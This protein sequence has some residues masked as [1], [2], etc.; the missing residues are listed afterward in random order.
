MPLAR[1]CTFL[2][3]AF[4]CK[5]QRQVWDKFS[6]RESSS[7]L[8]FWEIW[9][10]PLFIRLFKKKSTPS[11]FLIACFAGKLKE[12]NF[13]PV[14]FPI[15]FLGAFWNVAICGH[16]WNTVYYTVIDLNWRYCLRTKTEL[17][18]KALIHAL[19]TF[20]RGPLGLVSMQNRFQVRAPSTIMKVV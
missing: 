14:F 16:L 2:S 19:F 20:S 5:T 3:V 9:K 17:D 18:L 6:P 1:T 15:I 4:S 13:W 8:L 7:D 10:I 11:F 12:R